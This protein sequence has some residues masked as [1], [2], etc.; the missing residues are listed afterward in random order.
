MNKQRKHRSK[1]A[2][3]LIAACV[4]AYATL[5]LRA[6][7]SGADPVPGVKVE[8]YLDEVQEEAYAKSTMH[9]SG[10]VERESAANPPGGG[11]PLANII[12]QG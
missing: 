5:A 12:S 11:P 10:V 2:V 9:G 3:Y 4:A 7:S 1:R 8:R 6:T